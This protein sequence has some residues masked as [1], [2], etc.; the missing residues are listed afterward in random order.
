MEKIF[1]LI[2]SAD[3]ETLFLFSADIHT[4]ILDVYFSKFWPNKTMEFEKSGQA[5]VDKVNQLNPQSVLDI[6]CGYNPY[7]GK[8]N[9]LIGIDPYV[10]TGP[11][12]NQSIYDYFQENKDKQFDVVLCMGSI[13]FGPHNKIVQEIEMVDKLTKVGGHQFWRVNPG[14]THNNEK[15]PLVHLIEF[16][17]WSIEFIEKICGIYGYDILELEEETNANGDKRIYFHTVKL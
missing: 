14:I 4:L 8:I 2:K 15:F 1:N 13:N 6:G 10:R 5:L 16:F 17:P 3:D 9:N 7:K 12:I 11:D